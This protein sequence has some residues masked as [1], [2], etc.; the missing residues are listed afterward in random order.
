MIRKITA[1]TLSLIFCLCVFSACDSLLNGS[2]DNDDEPVKKSEYTITLDTQGG[3]PLAPMTVKA[4]EKCYS[5]YATLR[6]GY[7]FMGWYCNGKLWDFENDTVNDDITLTAGWSIIDYTITYDLGGGSYSGSMP[8]S[9]TV[10]SD[11]ISFGTPV[12]EDYVFLGWKINGKETN[13]IKKGTTEDMNVVA[14]WFGLEA[15]I[16]PA[17]GGATGIVSIIHDDARLPTMALLDAMLEKYGLVADVGFILNKVYSNNIT[18]TT[19]LAQ[20]SEYINNGRWKIVNHS[21]THTWWGEE[22][23]GGT[24]Y[25]Y[26]KDNP[27]RLSYEVVTSQQKMRELFPGQRVLTFALPGFSAERNKYTDGSLHQLKQIIYSPDARALINNNYIGSR[28]YS[29]GSNELSGD[30]DWG[31][32]NTRFL[33]ANLIKNNLDSILTTAVNQGNFEVLSIHGLTDD[34][35]ENESDP[36]YYLMNT[37]MYL[38]MSKINKYVDEGKLWNANFEDALLY[39]RE[40]KA[41]TLDFRRSGENVVINLTDDLS[42]DIYNAPLTIRLKNYGEWQAAKVVQGDDVQYATPKTENGETYLQFELVPDRGEA[43]ISA[44]SLED[45]PA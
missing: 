2:K 19:A 36:S 17:K 10:E 38:A 15:E 26:V 1:I 5:P 8:E 39:T 31:W 21:A 45:M 14:T 43:T 6:S 13:E 41:A 9:Y 34:P 22:I 20:Y 3:T 30:I 23:Y 44:V 33:S 32:V 7:E 4:G 35:A 27:D 25:S 18:D 12:R 37:D 29:G 42:D 40:A 16:T 24:G 11:T 28:F